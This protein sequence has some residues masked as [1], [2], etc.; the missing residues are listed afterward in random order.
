M[1]QGK[2]ME[3]KLTVRRRHTKEEMRIE[4]RFKMGLE[5]SGERRGQEGKKVERGDKNTEGT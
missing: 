5:V 3:G 2:V 1:V 4:M